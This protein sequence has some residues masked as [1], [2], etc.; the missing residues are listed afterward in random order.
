MGS[1]LSFYI[2]VFLRRFH[3]FALVAA[4]VSAAGIATAFLLPSK[5]SSQALLLV[6]PPQIP[7]NLA[8]S[9]IQTSPSEQ[10]QILQQRLLTRSNLL[11][12]ANEI[13]VF[14]QEGTLFPDEIVDR[15]RD[16][17]SFTISVGLNQASIVRIGYE[18]GDP[19]V[20]AAVVNNYVTRVLENNA[21]LR[22]GRA[23][24]TLQ[25]FEQEVERLAADLAAKSAAILQFKNANLHSLPDNLDR[26][27]TRADA[28][29]TRMGEIDRTII[30]LGQQ[31]ER[32]I[33]VFN[34]TG[35]AANNTI[36]PPSP[37]QQELDRLNVELA[38][39]VTIFSE[40]SPKLRAL[41]SKIAA[42][43]KIVAELD[44]PDDGAS[45]GTPVR[46]S[47]L[48]VQ[49]D[50]IDSQIEDLK[51]ERIALED[52][53]VKIEKNIDATPANAITLE[54]LQ[55]DYQNIQ[56][57]YNQSTQRLSVAATG[58][59][60]ELLSKGE[61]ISVINPPVVPREP[62]SPNRLLIAVASVIGG[63]LAGSAIVLML[64]LLNR[65]IRRPVDLSRA[66]GIVPIATLPVM[67]TPGEIARRR[68]V[69]AGVI[70]TSTVGI[71]AGIVFLH[72]QVMPLDLLVDRAVQSIGG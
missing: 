28:T 54:T 11:E 24:D 67:R 52:E 50:Q 45:D 42:L 60:I 53:L 62:T 13:G 2:S 39:A 27:L 23:E 30:S 34:A 69:M 57:Q 64:E 55:R 9:T 14:S 10:L 44:G 6:E 72:T 38:Q 61:R 41:R 70:M 33:L 35:G 56:D 59:R 19:N 36:N 7:A 22:K 8:S 20:S 4:I 12:I 5:F 37:E 40:Q 1:D 18:S 71:V 16:A 43:E 51:S 48:D 21:E 3:Y 29:R 66:L 15:M 25:F 65:S 17:T 58:E 68:T 47:M 32:L 63:L 46:F 26:Q 49:L 31:R